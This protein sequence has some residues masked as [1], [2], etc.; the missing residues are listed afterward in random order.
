MFE[1]MA[2]HE[3]RAESHVTD[4]LEDR[5]KELESAL[6]WAMA[7]INVEPFDWVCEED[8]DAHYAAIAA[9]AKKDKP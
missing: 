2:Q 7:N 9:L 3:Y 5:V 1:S 4:R 6:G 8:C